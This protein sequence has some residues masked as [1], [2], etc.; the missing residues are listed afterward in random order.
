MKTL[1]MKITHLTLEK[2]LIKIIFFNTLIYEM[3][4]VLERLKR[5]K[6]NLHLNPFPN[7]YQEQLLNDFDIFDIF[8][9]QTLFN[10][11]SYY[12]ESKSPILNFKL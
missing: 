9:S 11:N 1:N 3:N 7:Y 6:I 10:W 4:V 5:K 12:L 2:W 8:S